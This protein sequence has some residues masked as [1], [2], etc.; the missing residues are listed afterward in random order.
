[1]TQ[2]PGPVIVIDYGIGNVGSVVYAC[3]RIGVEPSVVTTG[4]EL[5]TQ[6]CRYILLPG[7]GAIGQALVNLRERGLDEALH[8]RVIEEGVPFLGICVG[9]Q[10][11]G[12]VCEEFGTHQ[13]F[14]WIPGVVRRLA[15][16]G[17]SLRLP[18]VGWNLVT[19]TNPDPLLAPV[20]GQHFYFVHSY[21]L[22]CPDEYVIARTE[23]GAKFCSAVRKGHIVGVQF[24]PEKSSAPGATLL[25]AFL[26]N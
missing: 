11:L 9:M 5:L 26:S 6:D 4:K 13:G 14:G 2:A 21:A 7:V 23:Y 18:H 22:Q 8:R 19:Q 25:S 1:M 20:D 15:P 12:E 3:R 10:V 17:S 24:H 16:S